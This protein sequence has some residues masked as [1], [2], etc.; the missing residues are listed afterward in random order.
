MGFN[1]ICC[2]QVEKGARNPNAKHLLELNRVFIQ[3]EVTSWIDYQIDYY[4][5]VDA[6]PASVWYQFDYD[7]SK[8]ERDVG[9]VV[10]RIIWDITHGGNLKTLSAA[11]SYVNLLSGADLFATVDEDNGTGTYSRL[12]AESDQDVAAYNYALEVMTAV[13]ANTAP[14]TVYQNITDD[15]V[16]IVDNIFVIPVLTFDIAP[17]IDPV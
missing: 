4:T 2:E 15:S 13:L 7:E 9:F 17:L 16:A 11:L 12:G 10:D 1:P 14:A 5:N 6:T 3:K 8:C